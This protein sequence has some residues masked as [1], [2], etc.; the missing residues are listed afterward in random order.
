MKKIVFTGIILVLVMMFAVTC[1]EEP[2]IDDVEY[3]DVVYSPD[4]S[5]VTVYFNGVKVPVTKAQRAMTRDLAMM[6]YDYLEVIFINSATTPAIARNKWELGQP[7]GINLG[8]AWR[9]GGAVSPAPGPTNYNLIT[10]ACL[11]AGKKS[12]KTLFGIGQIQPDATTVTGT[13]NIGASTESVTFYIRAILAG[14]QA[15]NTTTGGA[16]GQGETD[17]AAKDRGVVFDSLSSFKGANG[18]TFVTLGSLKY[19]LF[20][21]SDSVNVVN[22]NNYKFS[23]V[24]ATTNLSAAKLFDPTANPPVAQRR[25]PRFLDKGAYREP[26][27]LVNSKTKVGI[28]SAAIASPYAITLPSSVAADADFLTAFPS[29]SVPLAFATID[30]TATGYFSVYIEI[31]VYMVNKGAATNTEGTSF[32]T[33]FIRSGYGSELYSIDDGTSSAGCVLFG[34]GSTGTNDWLGIDWQWVQP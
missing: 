34:R 7:A 18:G 31:P 24:G 5:Q 30:P 8:A 28:G 32:V 21:L 29:A 33:W 13:V 22:G 20:Q 1:E 16:D 26:K 2:E 9:D 25:V 14:I 4:G 11:F 27:T 12:D 3:T 19:P 6:A 15:N 17:T 10:K 23:M